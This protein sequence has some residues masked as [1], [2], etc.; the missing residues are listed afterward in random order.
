MTEIP[1]Y[2]REYMPAYDKALEWYTEREAFMFM[3]CP[4]GLL[5]DRSPIQAIDDGDAEEVMMIFTRLNEGVY[6]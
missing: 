3:L 2:V 6:I 1:E 5:Q 4:N